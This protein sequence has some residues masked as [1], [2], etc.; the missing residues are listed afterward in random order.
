MLYLWLKACH[1]ISMVTWF[2]GLFYVPR[3]FVYHA[4]SSTTI[5]RERFKVMERRLYFGITTP[6]GLITIGLGLWLFLLNTSFYLAAPWMWAKLVCVALLIG[7]HFYCGYLWWQFRRDRNKHSAVFYRWLNEVPTVLL[8]GIIV[9][10][11][12]KPSLFC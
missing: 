2:A 5:E 7:F 8:V 12:V 10:V 11:V 4:L 9:L 3:L 6:G 1:I